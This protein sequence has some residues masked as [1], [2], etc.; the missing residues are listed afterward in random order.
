[1]DEIRNVTLAPGSLGLW[2]LGQGGWMVKSPGGIVL[3]VDPYLSDCC[4]PSRR[5]LDMRRRFPVPIPPADLAADL[6][7]CTHSHRDHA[8]PVTLA[9]S[10]PT[11]TIARFAGPPSC[12]PVFAAAGIDNGE[13]TWPGWSI[14]LGD[15]AIAATFAL[16]TDTT[17]LTHVGYVIAAGSGPKLWITGDTGWCELLVEDGLRHRPDAIAVCINAGFGNLSHWQAAQLVRR[18]GAGIA[19]PVHWDMFADNS[20]E[21]EMFKAS[22]AVQ[23]IADTYRRPQHGAMM[24][25]D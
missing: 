19:I 7:L 13:M 25:L 4:N 9:A 17:D 5:G 15:I 14:Q 11:G 22:L 1:M 6:L 10:A 20:C 23:G 18:V 12:Q 3:A 16:P 2:F 21:P 8:D 24:V